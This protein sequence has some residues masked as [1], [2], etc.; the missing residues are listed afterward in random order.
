MI[1]YI[2]NTINNQ[3]IKGLYK[4]M[5]IT[6]IKI[7]PYQGLLFSTNEKLKLLLGYETDNKDKRIH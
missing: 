7:I 3:G 5:S 6:Y 4:G 1:Q 2:K